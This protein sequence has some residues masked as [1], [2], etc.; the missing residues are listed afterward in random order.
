MVISASR[1]TDIPAF[2]FDWFLETLERGMVQV[3]NPYNPRHTKVIPLSHETVDAFVFWTKDPSY[4]LIPHPL[5]DPYPWI[6]LVTLTPYSEEWEPA[7][8]NKD[9][10]IQQFQRLSDRIGTER[11]VW[12]YDPIILTSVSTAGWHREMFERI[13]RKISGYTN[14][15]IV[16]F[17]TPYRKNRAFLTRVGWTNPDPEERISLLEDLRELAQR[18]SIQLVTCADPLSPWPGACI[19]GELLSR[20]VGKELAL[21]KDPSQRPACLCRKSVDIGTY[22][23][24]KGGCLYCYAK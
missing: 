24:C 9:F 20:V 5:L 11:V 10:L 16:S 7:F 2:F 22:G 6:V 8:P 1:R 12:R 21:K 15:C 4:L 13:A 14:R 19:D 17:V 3:T 18:E 23:T